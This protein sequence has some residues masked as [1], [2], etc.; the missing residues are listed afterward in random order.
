MLIQLHFH[1]QKL[2]RVLQAAHL[3]QLSADLLDGTQLRH[4]FDTAAC[5]AKTHHYQL[6]LHHPSKLFQIETSYVH[7]GHD[8]NL[9]LHVP[10]APADSILRLFQLHPFPLPFTESH[11]L[12][13]DPANQILTISSGIDRLSAE[14]SVATLMSCHRIN[15]AYLCKRHG[16]MQ[17]ELNSTC[18]GSLYVQDFPGTMTLCEMWIVEQTETVLQLQDNWYLVYLPVAF[19]SY[20]I[21][22]NNSNLEVFIKIGPNRIYISPSCR[23]C[24]KDHVLI[25]DSSMRLDSVIKHYKWDLD[26][27]AFSSEEHALSSR[28]LKILGTKNVGRPTLNCIRQDIAI[29]K[30]SSAWVY[31]FSILGVLVATV[32]AVTGAYFLWILYLSTLKARILHILL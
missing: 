27:I 22:L 11:F 3:H 31:L 9:I 23:M 16:V 20:I 28:W 26:K 18:L 6:M 17:R 10:K 2:T 7:N 14:I 12:M 32:I 19:T 24:L 15:S 13:P 29:E 30:C 5:K 21:C 8:I 25:S 1:L 4:I